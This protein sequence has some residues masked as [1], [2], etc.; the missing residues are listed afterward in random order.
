MRIETHI[1]AEIV[2]PAI[3]AVIFETLMTS[4]TLKN[5]RRRA[6][7]ATR[8]VDDVPLWVCE[9]EAA[10]EVLSLPSAARERLREHAPIRLFF[11]LNFSDPRC[12]G[13][14]LV[15]RTRRCRERAGFVSNHI[16]SHYETPRF[17]MTCHQY[18]FERPNNTKPVAK[19]QQRQLQK[20]RQRRSC[21][22]LL[23]HSHPLLRCSHFEDNLVC[24]IAS[25]HRAG[26]WL[27]RMIRPSCTWS[28]MIHS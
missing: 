16:V 19:S 15:I 22:Q 25:R 14:Y 7:D 20:V 2:K 13:K 11:S 8:D 18:V 3:G 6:L 24:P 4:G 5:F 28:S 26:T 27:G 17:L 12:V 1:S 21:L 10:A 9:V 23:K